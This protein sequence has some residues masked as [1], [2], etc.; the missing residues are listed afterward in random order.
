MMGAFDGIR[1]LDLS[2]AL[3]APSATKL[4]G[5]YGAQV[6]KV[7]API[8][9]DF[10]RTL[11]PWVFDSFNRNKQSIAIDLKSPE[12]Q[13]IVRDLARVSDV[14]VQS[15]RPGVVEAMGLGREDLKAVNP[16]LVYVSFSGFGQSGPSAERKGVDPLVQVETGMA[17]AQGGLIGS[18]SFVDAAAG[19]AMSGAIA[20]SLFKR[21]RTG[22]VDDIEM[23]LF[24][25]GLYLQTA[26]IL[27]ASVT[28]QML[29]Q[30][31]HLNRYPLS[32][33][34]EA[35]D[36]P[37]YLG[38]YWDTDWAALCEIAERPDLT[39]DARFA[40][41]PQRTANCDELLAVVRELLVKRPRRE[42]IDGLEMRGSMAGEV[43]THAEVLA[44]DQV[45]DAKSIE[46]LPTSRGP[47]GAY[48]K[49]PVRIVGRDRP[50]ATRAPH[51]GE[52]SE[53]ILDIIGM[54]SD[55][56]AS[57]RARGVID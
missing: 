19:L 51:V 14:V 30:T 13:Q 54:P 27:E 3:A 8:K 34:F 52:H 45:R 43:R 1:I 44:S 38:L 50:D 15:F 20:A 28:G 40:T 35:A 10:T 53:A 23:N 18:L 47:T 5:D 42:W 21:E 12:G 4:L 11:V 24:D 17:L 49:P 39:A 55:A 22:E 16:R 57:L 41:G 32:G 37:I 48:V 46:H 29:D 26:P 6:I 33:I 36:G 9:G 7:E 2:H 56:R 25:V 31:R